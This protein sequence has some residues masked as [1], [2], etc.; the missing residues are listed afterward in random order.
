MEMEQWMFKH[1]RMRLTGLAVTLALSAMACS[2]S[3]SPAAPSTPSIV[4]AGGLWTGTLT[5]T[6]VSGGE[7]VGVTEQALGIVGSSQTYTVQI[8]QTGT[9]LTAVTTSTSTGITTNFTGTAGTASV[10]LNATSS[11]AANVLGLHCTNGQL[12]LWTSPN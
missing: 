5:I 8:T 6:G 4:Q 12:R 11:S 3:S 7:C 10:T 1:G 9:S 2:G